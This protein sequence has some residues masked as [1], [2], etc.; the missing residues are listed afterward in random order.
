MPPE[1]INQNDP[2]QMTP[3]LGDVNSPTEHLVSLGRLI[4]TQNLRESPL[5][6]TPVQEP[7]SDPNLANQNNQ[8]A[9]VT[10]TA[11]PPQPDPSAV[12]EDIYTEI[13]TQIIK[14]QQRI[15]GDLAVEQAGLVEGLTVDPAT[16]RCTVSG[17]GGKVINNL[18]E[19]YR[20]FFGYAAVEVCKEAA[21]RFLVKLP[22]D[23]KP[24][25]LR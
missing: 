9:T 13:C 5:A 14:E 17:D 1:P 21:S 25:L 11:E 7:H 6:Q 23:E 18:I 12:K 3:E 10:A 16:F 19:Q 22:D 8:A 24:A 20:D 2:S 15:I 4:N